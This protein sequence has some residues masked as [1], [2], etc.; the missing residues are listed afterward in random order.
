MGIGAPVFLPEGGV[1]VSAYVSLPEQRFDPGRESAL[2]D[3]VRATGQG[4]GEDIRVKR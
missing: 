2:A 3:L 1:L 4:I